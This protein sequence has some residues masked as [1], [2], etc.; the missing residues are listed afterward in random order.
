MPI[1][2]S[3]LFRVLEDL[4]LARLESFEAALGFGLA[5]HL[6]QS[7]STNTGIIDDL[8]LFVGAAREDGAVSR[9]IATQMSWPDFF[10]AAGLP[11]DFSPEFPL[12]VLESGIDD[13]AS[14]AIQAYASQIG[15]PAAAKAAAEIEGATLQ[16]VFGSRESAVALLRNPGSSLVKALDKVGVSSTRL[17]TNVI[18][19]APSPATI[20]APESVVEEAEQFTETADDGPA[21]RGHTDQIWYVAI[22]PDGRHAVTTSDDQT[23]RVWDLTTIWVAVGLQSLH[24]PHPANSPPKPRTA[25]QPQREHRFPNI[26]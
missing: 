21:L 22:T 7:P 16:P 4:G 19:L 24:P 6:E 26:P 3:E 15:D 18:N 11:E 14:S 25:G 2:P 17:V 5:A 8:Q 1:K 10:L 23:A 12:S 20:L 13:S 9:V